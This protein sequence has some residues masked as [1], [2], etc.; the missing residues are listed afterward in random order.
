MTDSEPTESE[1]F[2]AE[3]I[4]REREGTSISANPTLLVRYVGFVFVGAFVFA[5]LSSILDFRVFPPQ[6][7]AIGTLAIGGIVGFGFANDRD[8]SLPKR[9]LSAIGYLIFAYLGSLIFP[10]P[11]LRLRTSVFTVGLLIGI[12]G[13]G[14]LW[15]NFRGHVLGRDYSTK[16]YGIMAIGLVVLIFGVMGFGL[17]GTDGGKEI[18]HESGEPN[19]LGPAD[20]HE[21]EFETIDY[22]ANSTGNDTVRIDFGQQIP[23]RTQVIITF[24]EDGVWADKISYRVSQNDGQIATIPIFPDELRWSEDTDSFTGY[25][26]RIIQVSEDSNVGPD[27]PQ[28]PERCEDENVSPENDDP[29][30]PNCDTNPY[31]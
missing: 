16:Q 21:I 7:P 31:D 13:G 6:Y 30:K 8:L 24:Y 10:P 12:L 29:M 20:N 1:D 26:V 11:G 22:I 28:P 3:K 17:L 25:E 19:Y 2:D 14:F 23:P 27:N 5:L 4:V 9:I 15:Y 18:N